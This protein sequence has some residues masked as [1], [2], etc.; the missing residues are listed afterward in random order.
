V[1]KEIHLLIIPLRHALQ[2]LRIEMDLQQAKYLLCRI[3]QTKTNSIVHFPTKFFKI[4]YLEIKT[5]QR[6]N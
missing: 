5:I 3:I 4:H 6:K 2:V 1:K